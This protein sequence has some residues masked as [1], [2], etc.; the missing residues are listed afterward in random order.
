MNRLE[1]WDKLEK[2]ALEKA[3]K[4]LKKTTAFSRLKLKTA[5]KMI[6]IAFRCEEIKLHWAREIQLGREVKF[7]KDYAQWLKLENS[8][9]KH[10]E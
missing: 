4:L 8:V 6:I 5:E 9:E 1:T 3:E 2:L 10:A 7:P